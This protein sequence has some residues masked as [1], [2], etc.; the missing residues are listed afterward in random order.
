MAA[1]GF[2]RQQ[3]LFFSWIKGV[4]PK[5]SWKQE[6]NLRCCY[7]QKQSSGAVLQT[8]SY[9]FRKIHKKTPKKRFR[10]RC[11]PVNSAKFPITSFSKNAS[12]G[13]F[14]I[15]IRF[16]YCPSLTFCLFKNDVTHFLAEY[17]FGLIC[18][19]GTRVSSIFQALS[20][21][22]IF[23]PVEHLRLSF[24]GKNSLQLKTVKYFRKKAPLWCSTRL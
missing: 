15:N 12:D 22:S 5:L 24:F 2:S 6:L 11:F 10:H 16:V 13:C 20:Q 18:R 17:F 19:L 1:S 14:V 21:K 3:I 23:N 8:C 4:C 7:N 9:K